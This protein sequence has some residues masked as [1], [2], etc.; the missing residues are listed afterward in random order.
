MLDALHIPRQMA[1]TRVITSLLSLVL[2]SPAVSDAQSVD[3]YGAAGPTIRDTGTSAAVGI[4][5]SP[6]PRLA[7]VFG[8]ER[9]HLSTRTST[10]EHGVITSFRG[11]T[12]FL[13][14]AELRVALFR[15]DRFG[16]YAVAG[17]AAGISRPNVNDRFPGRVT[18]HARTIFF[19]GGAR[20]P[21]NERVRV[22]GDVRLMVGV[23]GVEGI[24]AVVPARA[25]IVWAF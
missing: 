14:T 21:L 11:G 4:G 25:G 3:L 6:L 17:L 23:E 20:V 19:G 2:A 13:G 16:P 15:R 5:F 12:L 10:D 18:N 9:T 7:V 24:V 8:F 22:F 1:S